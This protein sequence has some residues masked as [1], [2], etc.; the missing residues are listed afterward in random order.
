MIT[1][2]CVEIRLSSLAYHEACN[3]TELFCLIPMKALLEAPYLFTQGTAIKA[4]VTASNELGSGQTSEIGTSIIAL[5]Q[6]VPH[7]PL[8]T[9]SF[10][11]EYTN[12]EQI[13]IM[14]NS[15]E[16]P[17]NGDSEIT[18]YNVQWDRGLQGTF[19]ELIGYDE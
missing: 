13:K 4:R 14:W 1:H 11:P 7:K 9:M 16:A 15:L 18:S 8:V 17:T 10:D 12:F 5:V 3:T 19:Y 6:T 2:Y